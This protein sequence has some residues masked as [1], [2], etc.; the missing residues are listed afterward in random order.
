MEAPKADSIIFTVKTTGII[1]YLWPVHNIYT[2]SF[3][4]QSFGLRSYAKSV[5][6]KD[7]KRKLKCNY[8]L[9]TG[10]LEYG[11]RKIKYPENI[12]S[13]FTLLARI[14]QES[15]DDLDTRWIKTDH[16][17]QLFDA[18]LLW[19]DTVRIDYQGNDVL[20]DHYRLDLNALNSN[21]KWISRSDYFMENVDHPDAIRQI[22]VQRNSPRKIIKASVK[23]H[24]FPVE[25]DIKS[26]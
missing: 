16:E 8:N 13:L 4:P 14:Q 20:C 15:A 2:T 24:G 18:R 12:H 1:H 22:W 17:G 5:S 9:Q 3:D 21:P 23:V 25:A 10:N 6:Q 7:F 19:A 26:D 11:S